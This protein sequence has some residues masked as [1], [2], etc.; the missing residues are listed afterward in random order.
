M[1]LQAFINNEYPPTMTFDVQTLKPTKSLAERVE[2][3]EGY[4]DF[5]PFF[6]KSVRFLDVG[7]NVGFFLKRWNQFFDQCIGIEP[8]KK[9]SDVAKVIAPDAEIVNIG[10]R[11]FSSANRF[12][13]VFIGNGPHHLHAEINGSEW[14]RKLAAFTKPGGYVL[15]EGPIDKSNKVFCKPPYVGFTDYFQV[16][17]ANWFERLCIQPTTKYTPNRYLILW[18][19][20]NWVDD[21]W[22]GQIIRKKY[23]HDKLFPD[24]KVNISV[25]SV[26]P[27]SNGIVGFTHNGWLEKRRN[28]KPL[29]RRGT[30]PNELSY[31]KLHLIHEKFLSRIG[32]WDI[33]PGIINF[34]K[35]GILFDKN[36]VIPIADIR[37]GN[38]AAYIHLINHHYVSVPTKIKEQL[39]DAI[40]TADSST[41]EGAYSWSILHIQRSLKIL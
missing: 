24:N 35:D 12:D 17:M 9:Y 20:K 36:G 13:R 15:T 5:S 18:Q 32:Y 38:S 4:K 25:A 40:D 28:E 6:E 22:S 19:R 16:E 21:G 14:V 1:D 23:K 10:F 41:I 31:F 3:I 8:I 33:D 7:C 2:I 27:I 37:Y 39:R 29:R 34:W 30:E 26:S 11:N